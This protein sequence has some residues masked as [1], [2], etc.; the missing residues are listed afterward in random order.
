MCIDFHTHKAKNKHDI[1]N[2]FPEENPAIGNFSIGIHPCF[3]TDNWQYQM[4]MVQQKSLLLNCKAIGECGLDKTATTPIELQTQI[5]YEHIFLSENIKKTLILHCVKA[6]SE[7]IS[8][9]K[10]MKPTQ[11]W[12]IHGFQKNEKIALELIQNG[13]ILSF[14]KAILHNEL[15]QNI[16]SKIGTNFLLETDN[17]SVSIEE[18]YKK[19]ADIKAITLEELE[20]IQQKNYTTIFS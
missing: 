17:A 15:L 1:Q 8:I 3:I 5:L 7:I 4:Q 14:G 10:K 18:I 19:V 20:C 13:F 11:T 2:Y 16:L 6:F 9:R 12:I